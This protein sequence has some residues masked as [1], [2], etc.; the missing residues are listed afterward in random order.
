MLCR[1]VLLLLTTPALAKPIVGRASIIDSDT[2]DVRG[3]RIRLHGID[4][5]ETAQLRK[6]GASEDYRCGQ[7]VGLALA[8]DVGPTHQ[9]R[10]T[11]KIWPLMPSQ[12]SPVVVPLP[13]IGSANSGLKF[14]DSTV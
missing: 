14:H 3:T 8:D 9:W 12:A 10:P 5:P 2:L 13:F 4:T 7:K 6:D 1:P 11:V